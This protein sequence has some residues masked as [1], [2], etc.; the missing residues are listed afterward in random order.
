MIYP[1]GLWDE[2]K[3]AAS[4]ACAVTDWIELSQDDLDALFLTG[5]KTIDATGCLCDVL[6]IDRNA[7][8]LAGIE[9]EKAM[10]EAIAEEGM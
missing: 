8:Y 3:P 7:G 1:F 5:T 10:A 6:N 2:N 9:E 4:T